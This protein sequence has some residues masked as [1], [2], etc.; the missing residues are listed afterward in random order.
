MKDISKLPKDWN[1]MDIKLDEVEPYVVCGDP[2]LVKS[3]NFKISKQ[4]AYFLKT[5]WAGTSEM[6]TYLKSE[7]QLEIQTIIK[8]ALGIK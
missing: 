6:R 4:L 2:S 7:A 3:E 8:N 5:H 1:V